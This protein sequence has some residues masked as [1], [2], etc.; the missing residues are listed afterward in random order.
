MPKYRLSN[1]FWDGVQMY[2]RNS[3]LEFE[4]GEAPR[5]SILVEDDTPPPEDD[6]K[7]ALAAAKAAAG[8]KPAVAKPANPQVTE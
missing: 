5:G 8:P 1:A 6:T 7:K 4:E 2:P 3:E